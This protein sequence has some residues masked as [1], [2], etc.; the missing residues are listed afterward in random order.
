M[1]RTTTPSAPPSRGRRLARVAALAA[2]TV[3][4]GSATLALPAHAGDMAATRANLKVEF[5]DLTLANTMVGQDAQ[6]TA[7]VTNVGTTKVRFS[8]LFIE[9]PSTPYGWR[10]TATDHMGRCAVD[11]GFSEADCEILPLAPGKTASATFVVPSETP[12]TY[13]IGAGTYKVEAYVAFVAEDGS[14]VMNK[15][16]TKLVVRKYPTVTKAAAPAAGPTRAITI[17]V[18]V[19]NGP[20]TIF[21]IPYTPPAKISGTVTVAGPEGVFTAPVVDGVANVRYLASIRGQHIIKIA[22]SGSDVS[23]GSST[24]VSFNVL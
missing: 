13:P 5:S 17:P 1:N 19:A 15:A 6:F 18:T 9:I 7:T 24:T 21:G 22:Y 23:G 20:R 2:A 16:T 3:A 8:S 4:L 11:G 12:D 10:T 14:T